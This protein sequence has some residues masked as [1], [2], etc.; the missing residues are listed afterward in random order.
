[1]PSWN[2]DA[3]RDSPLDLLVRPSTTVTAGTLERPPPRALRVYQ[4]PQFTKARL[5]APQPA[6]TKAHGKDTMQARSAFRGRKNGRQYEPVGVLQSGYVSRWLLVPRLGVL[7]RIDQATCV[8]RRMGLASETQMSAGGR[9][10]RASPVHTVMRNCSRDEGGPFG[11]RDQEP[12]PSHRKLLRSKAVVVSVAENVGTVIPAGKVK[13]GERKRTA[14]EASKADL[15]MSKPRG[16]PSCGTSS[17]DVLI[18]TERH[19]ACRRR[20]PRPGFR[21]ERE[22]LHCVHAGDFE[23]R[24]DGRSHKRRQSRGRQYRCAATGAEQPVVALKA[25]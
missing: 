12:I 2:N 24:H 19:P 1:M 18:R 25:L 8:M 13:G 14:A 7:I 17:G 20:E 5:A 16:D 11:F 15:A 9:V 4:A 21:T 22:N 3:H 6:I 23:G 10:S